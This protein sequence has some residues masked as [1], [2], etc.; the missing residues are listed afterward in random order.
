MIRAIGVVAVD[1]DD[2]KDDDH[3]ARLQTKTTAA[4]VDDEPEPGKRH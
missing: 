2:D 4:V 3:G 1:V